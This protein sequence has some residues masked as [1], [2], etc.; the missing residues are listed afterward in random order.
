MN[1]FKKKYKNYEIEPDEIFLDSKNI[2][3]FDTN[4]FEG[5]IEKPIK[6][7]SLIFLGVSFLMI[8]I[9]FFLKLS[10]LQIINGDNF[11]KKSEDNS[12][13]TEP[14]FA[15]R[16][17]IK[18]RNGVLLAWNTFVQGND[19]PDRSYIN[20]LGFAHIVGY[21]SYPAK[22]Q[23][24][25]Y[26]KKEF[27]GKD[28]VEKKYDVQLQ[29]K[30]G[31]KIFETDVRGNIQSENIIDP[32][33]QGQSLLLS[34]DSNMQKKM[35]QSIS[36]LAKDGGFV[37]GAGIVMDINNG[38][39]LT[40]T[41]YPE[42]GAEILSKGDNKIVINEYINS[43]S[44]VLLNRAVGGLYVP[45]SII[46]PFVAIGALNE[47][48]INS[49]KKILSTGSISLPNPYF[50]EQKTIFKDWKAH[51]WTDMREALAVS[52]DVYFYEI[53][54]GFQNQKGLGISNI[55]KYTRMFGIGEKTNI[56]IFGELRG[57]IPSPEWKSLIF[58][59]DAWR[60]G[61]TYHTAIGQ[62]GF[63]TTPVQMVRAVS[64]IASDGILVT[65]HILLG[66]TENEKSVEIPSMPIEYFEVVKEGMRMAVTEGTTTLMNLPYA[67]AAAK[68]G[69]AQTG[70]NNERH[71]SWIIGFFP[72]ENPKY[73]F[74]VMMESAPKA[75]TLGA[76]RVI[77]E[78]LEWANTYA[79]EYTK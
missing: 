54:G 49:T 11:L 60:V 43:K 15:D 14:L 53:G 67:H 7:T 12:L 72:Y 2:P 21:V 28:G 78:L 42:Y 27:V 30:N 8:G 32:P 37:G 48:V 75:S 13:N 22:D 79:P 50:P 35:Y 65:P 4:Q 56:D 63:Q 6:K 51:G 74:A 23:K 44:K 55:E 62:Y 18:D 57:T 38:E 39:V 68:S 9:L 17:L 64:A 5:R 26:W 29:G 71:H 19:F 34:I 46:K 45:G 24:G 31:V 59:G 40:M 61:D 1:I 10:S 16:G 66:D 3:Q 77:K 69:T 58:K 33:V 41:S 20:D 76:T 52:S 36:S 25:I 47:G 70:I 73:A